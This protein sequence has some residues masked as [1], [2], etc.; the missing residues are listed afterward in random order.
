MGLDVDDTVEPTIT[1]K[2]SY[3]KNNGNIVSP[4]TGIQAVYDHYTLNSIKPNLFPRDKFLFYGYSIIG[5]PSSASAFIQADIQQCTF[6]TSN[7]QNNTFEDCGLG[8]R[9]S[10]LYEVN[11]RFV[12]D[13]L[14]GN[15]SK[16]EIAVGFCINK[17]ASDGIN[18]VHWGNQY[19]DRYACSFTRIV[20]LDSGSNLSFNYFSS[21][22][23]FTLGTIYMG[24]KRI[25]TE[26]DTSNADTAQSYLVQLNDNNK[27]SPIISSDSIYNIPNTRVDAGISLT[28]MSK[29]YPSLILCTSSPVSPN[30]RTSTPEIT[31]SST[32]SF[33]TVNSTITSGTL[34]FSYYNP[35]YI[36]KPSSPLQSYTIQKS[37]WY[38][39]KLNGRFIDTAGTAADV[40]VIIGTADEIKSDSKSWV[41]AKRIIYRESFDSHRILHLDKNDV[42]HFY[43]F[44]DVAMTGLIYINTSIEILSRD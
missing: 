27:V 33:S 21:N 7:F 9:A 42:L 25:N 34:S 16:R 35:E 31:F 24:V 28:E 18:L 17:S 38:L 19:Y 10:G 44:N 30:T 3:I 32:K 22:N 36:S 13:R 8:A 40:L 26:I 6:G 41:Y 2:Q 11:I 15:Y 23:T 5:K 12:A 43:F 4:R 20:S 1:M 14:M 29:N 37:G 39:V